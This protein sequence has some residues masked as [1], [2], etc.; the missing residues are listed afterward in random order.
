LGD[1]PADWVSQPEEACKEDV[2]EVSRCADRVIIGKIP[3][4]ARR[5]A[6]P[7]ESISPG[8]DRLDEA[9]RCET[10]EPAGSRWDSRP[11][12][13]FAVRLLVL[14]VPLVVAFGAV[15]FVHH[16]LPATMSGWSVALVLALTALVT[17]VAAERLA[18][19]LLPLSSLL[20]MTMLFPDR[21]PSRLRVFRTAVSTRQLHQKLDDSDRSVAE[22][23]AATLALITALGGHDR[24]TRGHSERVRA[25]A[26]LLAE[27]LNLCPADRDRLRWAALLHDIG[28]LEIATQVLNKRGALDAGEWDRVRAHPRDGTRLAGPLMGWL[29]EWGGGIGEHHERYDGTGYP[30]GLEAAG[31]SRA[32]RIV[33]VIDAF[34]TMTA[35]RTYQQPRSTRAARAELARCAGSHFD[36]HIVRAF[37]TISLP[38][39]LWAMGPLAFVVHLP[40]LR[41]L[42]TAGAHVGSA[43]ATGAGATVIA[44]GAAVVPTAPPAT[45]P[46]AV[47]EQVV[48]PGGSDQLRSWPG[49]PSAGGTPGTAGTPAAAPATQATG[50]APAP[51]APGSPAPGPLPPPLDPIV[52]P[53]PAEPPAVRP[54]RVTRTVPKRSKRVV[55]RSTRVIPRVGRV[56]K[57]TTKL[58]PLPEKPPTTLPTLPVP[59]DL[60]LPLPGQTPGG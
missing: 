18:R 59:K 22:A 60:P 48:V 6:A 2:S 45:P 57:R 1:V 19:R 14:A 33:A 52:T 16:R 43:V 8:P 21:A 5:R 10:V 44:V 32:G 47:V 31:I 30:K 17:G 50:P 36:P 25:F 23:A 28:K 9:E 49:I 54:P 3:L 40:Y 58:L 13:G 20:G 37:L 15:K 4:S 34:E 42:E 27:Q 26:D 41:S 53:T 55:V 7:G 51:A 56:V 24:R 29:G 46:S 39:L 35:A 38:R 12:L 11:W